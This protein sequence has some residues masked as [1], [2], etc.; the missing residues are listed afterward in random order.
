VGQPVRTGKPA[1]KQ[2][3]S[4]CP[5]L[6]RCRAHA[7]AAHEPY[8]VWGGLSESERDEIIRASDRTLRLLSAPIPQPTSF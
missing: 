8:G 4:S 1:R 3:C 2:I 5:V 6:A 7:L